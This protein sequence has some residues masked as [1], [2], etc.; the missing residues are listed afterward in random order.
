M[1]SPPDCLTRPRLANPALD[2]RD[3]EESCAARVRAAS[4]YTLHS[5]SSPPSP[6]AQT[7]EAQD[8]VDFLDSLLR[9]IAL[10]PPWPPTQL[11]SAKDIGFVEIKLGGVIV[12][13]DGMEV[14]VDHARRQSLL[15]MDALRTK[16]GPKKV[17]IAHGEEA[18]P[19]RGAGRKR[20]SMP[21]PPHHGET[22]GSASPP[23]GWEQAGGQLRLR[24][25]VETLWTASEDMSAAL[26]AGTTLVSGKILEQHFVYTSDPAGSATGRSTGGGEPGGFGVAQRGGNFFRQKEATGLVAGDYADP[27]N[28]RMRSESKLP[29]PGEQGYSAVREVRAAARTATRIDQ[30]Y[31]AHQERERWWLLPKQGAAKDPEEQ[32]SESQSEVRAASASS[33][34][35]A[36]C[37]PLEAPCRVPCCASCMAVRTYLASSAFAGR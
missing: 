5:L 6:P 12:D 27:V 29:L 22:S 20:S 1:S 10:V 3:R 24:D 11:R 30:R 37:L 13:K 9:V 31:L 18:S 32:E 16:Q 8:Y 15:S 19:Q 14:M 33:A 25:R 26:E 28:L 7:S 4:S 17:V 2:G 35:A 23:R 21:V 34:G 36:A